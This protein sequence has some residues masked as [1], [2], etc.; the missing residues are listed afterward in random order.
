V[1]SGIVVAGNV[2]TEQRYEYT[3]IG[4]AVNEAS[5]LTEIAKGRP[6]RVLA[7]G[8]ALAQAGSEA[9][10]WASLGNVAI[11]GGSEPLAIYEPLPVRVAG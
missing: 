11:R 6:G 10:Q 9:G 7:A 8:S 5:R 2:G 4:R 1:S 3:V